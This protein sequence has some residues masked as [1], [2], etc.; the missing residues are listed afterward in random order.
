MEIYFLITTIICG[1]LLIRFAIKEDKKTFVIGICFIVSVQ[2][3][4]STVI[5]NRIREQIKKSEKRIIREIKLNHKKYKVFYFE[6]KMCE[7]KI[8]AGL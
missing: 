6:N 2:V 7:Y 8:K 4:T 1:A 5:E 3:F